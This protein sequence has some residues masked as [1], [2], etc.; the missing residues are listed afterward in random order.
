MPTSLKGQN[1]P[2]LY[3]LMA[4]NLAV[5][6]GVVQHDALVGAD[7]V[8]LAGRLGETVPAAV[9]LALTGVLNALLSPE[10]KARIV[11][12]R[13]RDPLPGAEAFTR[14]AQDDPRVD[15]AALQ[16][17]CGPLPVTPREQNALWYRLYKSVEADPS[18]TQVHRAFLFTRDYACLGLCMCVVLGVAGFVQIPSTRT[19]LGYFALLVAQFLLAR[20]AARNHGV[21]FVT[22]VLALKSAGVTV[23]G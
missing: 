12:F 16:T 23:K 2:G 1:L 6:Y 10:A 8:E 17:A 14:H 13:W 9:A 18:V 4:A 3:A 5:F 15:L 7:W 19:A 22:T 21:R 11:F 20:R